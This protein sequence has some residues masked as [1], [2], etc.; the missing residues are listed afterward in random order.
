MAD[1]PIIEQRFRRKKFALWSSEN[2]QLEQVR[3][4]LENPLS[5]SFFYSCLGIT[6]R[7]SESNRSICYLQ[8]VTRIR[9]FRVYIFTLALLRTKLLYDVSVTMVMDHPSSS[10]NPPKQKIKTYYFGHCV[11]YTHELVP[12]MVEHHLEFRDWSSS[13]V[14][15]C[16]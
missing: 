9:D 14:W 11:I 5:K 3:I 4:S 10:A 12:R 16:L 15:Q 7:W 13:R 1:Y 6:S 8:A 2:S